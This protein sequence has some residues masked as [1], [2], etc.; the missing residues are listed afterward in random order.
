MGR[1][2]DA[3]VLIERIYEYQIKAIDTEDVIHSIK[4]MPTAYDI[5]K[6]VAE[7]SNHKDCYEKVIGQ[8]IVNNY[9][10]NL[11]RVDLINHAIEIARMGGIDG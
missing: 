5:E 4:T 10:I 7:L 6:V 2:I 11:E 3:D 1:L 9:D 8:V